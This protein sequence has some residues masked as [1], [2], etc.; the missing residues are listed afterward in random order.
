MG[1]A[2]EGILEVGRRICDRSMASKD[3]KTCDADTLACSS[4]YSS[5]QNR[6]TTYN[7]KVMT[8]TMPMPLDS[9]KPAR[10]LKVRTDED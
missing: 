9:R 3:D 8:L 4:D 10:V 2:F 5:L 1:R 6:V 7:T